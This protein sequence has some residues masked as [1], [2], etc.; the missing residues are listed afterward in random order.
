MAWSRA[1]EVQRVRATR[2]TR[3]AKLCLVM[4]VADADPAAVRRTLES[5]RRQRGAWSLTVV[6]AEDRLPQIRALVHAATA[7]RDRRRIRL[8]G[9]G[10]SGCERDLLGVGIEASR[11]LPT[12]PAL[13]R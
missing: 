5:V 2:S 12:R 9:A 13:P 7:L 11:G 4:A 8:V 1:R 6:T 3:K 10:G